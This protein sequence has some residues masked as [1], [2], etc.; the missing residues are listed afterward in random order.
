MLSIVIPSYNYNVVPLVTALK[1]QAALLSINFEILVQDD[2]SNSELNVINQQI[3][4]LENC[5]FE[6]NSSNLGRAKNRNYLA[7][8]S[9][10]DWLLF[11]DCDMMPTASNYLEKYVTALKIS[12]K[13]LFYGGIEYQI[14]QKF[15]GNLRYIYGRT[16]EALSV[17]KRILKKN[18]GA[19]TS[20]LLIK[21]VVFQ[22]NI[23]SETLTQ[24]GYEDTLFLYELESKNFEVEHINNEL[25]HL[26]IETSEAFLDKTKDALKNLKLIINLQPKLENRISVAKL[27]FK[28]KKW[29][30][31]FLVNRVYSIFERKI[32]ANLI[33]NKPSLFLY[34]VFK[35]GYLCKSKI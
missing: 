35:I 13:Q 18:L 29:N 26:N 24:Y 14:D 25:Y 7:S 19:Q 12:E 30:L 20:N 10:Y 32:V 28:L 27:Y 22:Q 15:E 3:N 2:A 9:K 16:R 21:K 1:V 34:D 31:V 6:T 11:I 4:T 8:K 23:F 5:K 33:S 17:E